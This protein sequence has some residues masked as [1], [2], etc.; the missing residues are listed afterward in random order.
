MHGHVV[1]LEYK[2]SEQFASVTF[3]SSE[4]AQK[5]I[6]AIHGKGLCGRKIQCNASV[7]CGY[8]VGFWLKFLDS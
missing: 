6:Y 4:A 8:G 2:P 7:P 3:K 1:R 5:A